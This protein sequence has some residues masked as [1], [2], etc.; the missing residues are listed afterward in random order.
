M[1]LVNV[2]AAKE[3]KIIPRNWKIIIIAL[4]VEDEIEISPYP[5]V[6]RVC[7]VK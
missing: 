4:S 3:K 5:T 2:P 1:I 6:V 7:I